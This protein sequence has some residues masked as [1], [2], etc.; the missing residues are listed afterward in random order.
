V[1]QRRISGD[2]I[3]FLWRSFIICT[4]QLISN[5]LRD[6]MDL[7]SFQEAGKNFLAFYGTRNFIA[8][9]TRALNWS[10]F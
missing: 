6:F 7:S 8:T 1:K 2:W 4:N 9:S 10:I 5:Q 3:T